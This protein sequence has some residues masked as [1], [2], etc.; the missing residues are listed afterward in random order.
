M[1]RGVCLALAAATAA[2]SVRAPE[3]KPVGTTAGE[4]AWT[5]TS[6]LTGVPNPLVIGIMPVFHPNEMVKRFSLL[7]SYIGTQLDTTVELRLS[8]SYDEMV[9]LIATGEVDLAQL[10]PL[11]Y[12]TAKEENPKL[13][14][15]ATNIAEGSSTY[16]GYIVARTELNIRSLEDLENVR[17]AFVNEHSTSGYLYPYAFLLSGGIDPRRDFREIV[18]TGRHDTLLHYLVSGRIEAGATF[19]GTLLHAERTGMDTEQIEI[20]AKT[21]RIPY[22]AWVTRSGLDPS[23]TRRLR[24]SLLALSTRDRRGRRILG[25]LRSINAFAPTTDAHYDDVRAVKRALERARR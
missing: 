11:V 23:V 17:F 15:I 13:Q 19:S 21:G 6:T 8:E 18:M 2:C 3:P 12:V 9:R 22:D 24:K 10:S 14:L 20:V 25:P 5:E 16:S 1:I 4:S 7:A